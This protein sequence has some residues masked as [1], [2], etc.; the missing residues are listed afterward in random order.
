MTGVAAALI[1]TAVGCELAAR[2]VL[3][4]GTDAAMRERA[5][6]LGS[7]PGGA[8]APAGNDGEARGSDAATTGDPQAAGATG[9]TVH[10]FG[11]S[12]QVHPFY[13]YTAERGVA[14][15]N[16]QGFFSGGRSFP[17]SKREGEFV[18]GLFGG[19]V[20]MQVAASPSPL[21]DALLPEVRARGYDRVT[22]LCFAL[23]GWRQPQSFFALVS[24]LPAL[25]LILNLDGFNEVIHTGDAELLTYPASY[26]WSLVYAAL[27]R[28]VPTSDDI[29]RR[30]DLIR[31]NRRAA[32]VTRLVQ[33]SA[34]RRSAFAHLVWRAYAA[35]YAR[36]T[37]ELREATLRDVSTEFS[38]V[39]P[40]ENG[41][42]Q[43]KRD[44]YLDLYVDLVRFSS[45]IAAEKG[46]PFFHFVQ[47]NQYLRDSKPL[48]D[49]ERAL[50]IS[51]TAWFDLV[52]PQYRALEER[53]RALRADGVE[54]YFFGHLFDAMPETIYSDDCCHLNDRGIAV[55]GRAMG[56][57]IVRSGRLAGAPL[58]RAGS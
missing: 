48:S 25:D 38:A 52:T 31:E 2:L 50:R 4:G 34:L 37:S 26:P 8:G 53:T 42:I 11:T 3:E 20:A 16:N 23:P 35:G 24:N 15:A 39:E 56:D 5:D 9:G 12:F 33:D 21:L 6:F 46:K 55:L 54:S 1:L 43:A 10:A 58:G 44:A 57:A 17:Y 49:E 22:L 40:I 30:A 19:S 36:R 32:R 18:V 45:A 7:L 41:G 14:G 13:G 51:N 27:A 29:L 28:S 47:P